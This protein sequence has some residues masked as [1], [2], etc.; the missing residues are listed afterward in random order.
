[1]RIIIKKEKGQFAKLTNHCICCAHVPAGLQHC[2]WR[3]RSHGI[4]KATYFMKGKVQTSRVT[5]ARD[6]ENGH[7]KVSRLSSTFGLQTED[8]CCSSVWS[9]Q[10]G[11]SWSI[12]SSSSD[13]KARKWCLPR[14]IPDTFQQCREE[15]L[16]AM[17]LLS[18][19][20]RS[21]LLHQHER[22]SMS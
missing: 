20:R 17:H 7:K 13:I 6:W 22:A 3:N 9:S 8:T 15:L 21:W 1:M 19:D 16:K 14:A 12:S 10:M 18:T 5:Y 4:E 11:E 2:R